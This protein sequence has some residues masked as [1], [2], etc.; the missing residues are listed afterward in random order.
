MADAKMLKKAPTALI[1]K[2]IRGKKK[3]N[4]KAKHKV[5]QKLKEKQ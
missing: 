1:I 3:T 5:N 2:Q 4:N